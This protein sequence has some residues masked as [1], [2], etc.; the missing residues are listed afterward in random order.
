MK[1]ASTWLGAFVVMTTL[2]CAAI[3]AGEDVNI[4]PSSPDAD[5]P[6]VSL[7]AVTLSSID[8]AA[9]GRQASYQADA[10]VGARVDQLEAEVAAL[11][12][13]LNLHAIESAPIY[14]TAAP[15]EKSVYPN[16][17]LTGFFQVDA[18]WFNQD[19][20]SIAQFQD[21]Q[22]DRGFRRARL[23]AVGDVAE[24]TS[25]MMEFDFAFPGR[26][27]FMDVWLE[28]HDLPLVGNMRIGQFRTYFGMT[29]MTSARELTFLERPLPAAFAPF[30]QTGIAFHDTYGDGAGTWGIGGFGFPTD[31]YGGSL[32][33]DGYGMSGRLTAL[34]YQSPDEYSFL[35][36]GGGY[37]LVRPTGDVLQYRSTPEYGGP[38]GGTGGTIGDVPF[39][40][41]TNSFAATQSQVVNAELA[42]GVG[43]LY[44]QSEVR[45]ATVNRI[46]SG[47]V[48][49]PGAYVHTGYF[50]TGERRPY[51]RAGGVL[52][53]VVPLDPVGK[54]GGCGAWEIAARYSYIDLNQSDI[55]GGRLSD[56]TLGL[57]WYL[58]QYTKFQ[59]NYIRAMLDRTPSGDSDTNIV[60]V[61]AQLDF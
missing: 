31:F 19:A 41:D 5:L 53:R 10:A 1:A 2:S 55:Q 58:N 11:R 14:V 23:A 54:C 40:V 50:L 33:D 8:A 13:E 61:R 49:F 17:R 4:V 21:I 29:E 16:A 43:S 9:T 38:F 47:S 52:G 20:A 18:G 30:R 37:V 56:A 46:G 36:V 3:G 42:G 22:D 45:Y 27:S 7:P 24:S 35:H 34:A 59:L 12:N 44:V 51:N 39:F 25:Y 26:P 48:T 32:G 57:N 28:Q 15:A 6:L 60:G